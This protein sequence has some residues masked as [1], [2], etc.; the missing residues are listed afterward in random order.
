MNYLISVDYQNGIGEEREI[1]TYWNDECGSIVRET[2]YTWSDYGE[3]G[4]PIPTEPMTSEIQ[5]KVDSYREQQFNEQVQKQ[6][7]QSQL[8]CD[9]FNQRKPYQYKGQVVSIIGGRKSNGQQGVVFWEGYDRY[10]GS[11]ESNLNFKASTIL[12]IINDGKPNGSK[13]NRVGI[14]LSNGETEFVSTD[15]VK[16][17]EGFSP[18]KMNEDDIVKLVSRRN[19]N[20]KNLASC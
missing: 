6:M 12:A 8:E 3:G 13:F 19:Q 2:T 10:A 17:V 11:V 7:I 4:T 16:V 20:F 5:A 14:R 15:Y 18:V 1:T 9:E